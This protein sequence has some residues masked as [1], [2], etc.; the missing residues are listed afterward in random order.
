MVLWH[1]LSFDL[2]CTGT[3][4]GFLFQK[5]NDLP[6]HLEGMMGEANLK[7]AKGDHEEAI[8]ICM[9]IIRMGNFVIFL[10]CLMLH[11]M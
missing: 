10:L 5:Y 2:I 11:E 7:F 9:E 1:S 3:W 4:T 6:I 8:S